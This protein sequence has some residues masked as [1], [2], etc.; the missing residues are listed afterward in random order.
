MHQPTTPT[1]FTL[2]KFARE[3]RREPERSEAL[4]W[5]QLR[6]RQ[7]GVH[8][9]RQ[10][11]FPLGYIVDFYSYSARLVVE[12][13]GGWHR[14]AGEAERDAARQRAIEEVYGVRFLR[15]PAELVERD[16][17]AAVARVRAALR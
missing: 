7:V 13:D 1:L 9:R 12:V 3:H 15:L 2:I 10:H 14:Q 17:F 11:P 16:T 4:L 5:A 8:F 6:R